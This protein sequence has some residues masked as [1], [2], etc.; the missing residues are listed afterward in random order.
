MLI[1]IKDL[2]KNYIM[3]EVEVPAL[4]KINL[5][6]DRNEY[7]AIM[8]GSIGFREINPDEHSWMPR[9]TYQWAIPV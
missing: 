7:V 8:G 5:K 1:E 2:T 6:I 9:Y 4:K 3:G